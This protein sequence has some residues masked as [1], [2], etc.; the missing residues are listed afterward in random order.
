MSRQ[1]CLILIHGTISQLFPT[2]SGEKITSVPQITSLSVSRVMGKAVFPNR[3]CHVLCNFV[4]SV[5]TISKCYI[6]NCP[7]SMMFVWSCA[8]LK[9]GKTAISDR[10]IQLYNV[11]LLIFSVA[12]CMLEFALGTFLHFP[13]FF[14]SL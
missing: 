9:F 8:L 6:Q 4:S 14:C 2:N 10:P 11:D 13:L 1:P 3:S 12:Y 7:A 5:G